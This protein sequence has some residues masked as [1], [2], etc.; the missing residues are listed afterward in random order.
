MVKCMW[1]LVGVEMFG[2]MKVGFVKYV[3]IMGVW[4][5]F[6]GGFFDVKSL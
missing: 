6:L 3:K 1:I 4:I 5:N 2:F